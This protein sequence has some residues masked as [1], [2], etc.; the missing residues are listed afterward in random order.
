[1]LLKLWIVGWSLLFGYM[2]AL[3][4]ILL[5]GQL[6]RS[7]KLDALVFSIFVAAMFYAIYFALSVLTTHLFGSGQWGPHRVL[8]WTGPSFLVCWVAWVVFF[9]L[10]S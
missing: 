9:S 10:S 2:S 6:S 5:A 4:F 8:L 1:M 7:I 3:G